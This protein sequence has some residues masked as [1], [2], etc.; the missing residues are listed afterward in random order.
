[1]PLTLDEQAN[2]DERF[3]ALEDRNAKLERL[4]RSGRAFTN[5]PLAL[6]TD[7]DDLGSV[8]THL[9]FEEAPLTP[10]T[11]PADVGRLYVRN[12]SNLAQLFYVDASG[13][14][15]LLAVPWENVVIDSDW[16]GATTG[17]ALVASAVPR[18]INLS[19]GTTPNSTVY[20][21]TGAVSGFS[22]GVDANVIDWSQRVL[23]TL[24]FSIRANT[25]TGI[26]RVTLGKASADGMG[27]LNNRGIGIQIEQLSLKGHV[28]D[29]TSAATTAV[30]S[31]LTTN[32]AYQL[33]IVSDGAGNIEWFLDGTSIGT[34][35]AGPSA[36]G[37]A[38]DCVFQ[39]D[40]A[41]GGNSAI[42]S[43]LMHA[44]QV[45]AW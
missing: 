12:L 30:L 15:H 4:L 5:N 8:K 28:H 35:A 34:S 19:S 20:V 25:S 33:L 6:A 11:P 1:M 22:T 9:D 45:A 2:L 21:Q 7:L 27:A 44:L 40:V 17:S 31:T 39:L 16:S 23:V 13:F 38:G 41:N 24:K 18:R 26:V 10:A 36:A 37:V 29:G 3:Q 42:Q 14:R 32:Q 43:A